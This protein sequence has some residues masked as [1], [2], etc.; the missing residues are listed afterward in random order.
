MR[1][2]PPRLAVSLAAALLLPPAAARANGFALDI[3]GVYANGTAGAAAGDPR[4][5]AVQFVNPAALAALGGTRVTAGG[6]LVYPR[7]PYTDGGSTLARGSSPIVGENGD[8]ATN[9][10]VPWAFLS[11]WVSPSVTVGFGLTTPFGLASD[12]GR[13]S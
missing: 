13:D 9:G 11:Q 8:G 3:Q 1:P 4:D 10:Q 7:A 5:P 12:Y 6:M 2:I